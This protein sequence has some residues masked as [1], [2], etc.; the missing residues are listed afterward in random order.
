MTNSL[1]ISETYLRFFVNNIDQ[2]YNIIIG[3]RRSAKSFSTYKW[4]RFLAS[5][6]PVKILVV[7]ATYPA[8]TLTM[9]DFERATGLTVQG[10]LLYGY[11]CQMANGSIFQFRAFDTSTKAQGT[12]C[13]YLFCEEFLNIDESVIR[14]LSMS[15]TRSIYLVANP[16][17]KNKLIDDYTK[18]DKSNYL[19]T[20]YLDNPYLTKEQV[21][22]FEDIKARS[23]APNAT[24]YDK[25]CAKVYVDGEFGDLAGRVFEKLES[26][27]YADYWNIPSEEVLICDL[28]F[29]GDDFNAVCGFKKYNSRLYIHTYAYEKGSINPKDFA[30]LL[31]R[32]GFNSS[33][34]VYSDYGGIGRQ[35]LDNVI[36]AGNGEWTEPELCNGFCINNVIKGN[37]LQSLTSLMALDGI[38]IDDSDI[39]TTQEFENAE[40][41]SNNNLKGKNDHSIAC[42]R[43]AINYFHFTGQ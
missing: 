11:S 12:S 7:C 25:W 38:V 28:A 3:G 36:T 17:K 13:D 14:T 22:E 37:V 10:S 27:T 23:L 39:R 21:K 16:T 15:V 6:K 2:R 24:T 34:V 31:V 41:D 32:C 18:D 33:T 35:I 5:G 40:F 26:C 8:L 19:K 30:W 1:G 20:T 4:L 9:N 42:A 29:G 43:Y